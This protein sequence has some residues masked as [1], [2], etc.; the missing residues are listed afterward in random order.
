[1]KSPA[2]GQ[3]M[4]GWFNLVMACLAL[5]RMDGIIVN[6][7]RNSKLPAEQSISDEK[8]VLIALNN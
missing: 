4:S 1:V 2:Y 3:G 8:T 5:P 6:T 7:D